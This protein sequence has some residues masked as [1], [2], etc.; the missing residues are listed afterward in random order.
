MYLLCQLSKGRT[1]LGQPE[2]HSET[3]SQNVTTKKEENNNKKNRTEIEKDGREGDRK[4]KK[5]RKTEV[6]CRVSESH[7]T[8]S[9]GLLIIARQ[10]HLLAGLLQPTK[11]AGY[12]AFL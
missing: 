8:L 11:P 12:S 10:H 4:R 3:Q 9:A 5:E 1:G 2:L 7:T 6:F